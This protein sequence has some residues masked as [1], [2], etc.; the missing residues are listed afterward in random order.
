MLFFIF[1]NFSGSPTLQL[2]LLNFV[3]RLK[4][5]VVKKKREYQERGEDVW[6]IRE[7]FKMAR[8]WEDGGKPAVLNQ[9][10]VDM[11]LLT[12]TPQG[13]SLGSKAIGH[14]DH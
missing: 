14:K 6:N 10:A 8:A 1:S 2:F 12:F 11:W 4:K 5:R 13:F 9:N 7:E 3:S